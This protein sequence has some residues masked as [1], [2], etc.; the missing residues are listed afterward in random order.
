M[1]TM[2][3]LL[4]GNGP[5]KNIRDKARHADAVI[6]INHCQYRAHIPPEKMSHVFVVNS[7]DKMSVHRVV[8]MLRDLDVPKHTQIVFWGHLT[9]CSK[10]HGK[11]EH[12]E[13]ACR[14]KSRLPLKSVLKEYFENGNRPEI[15]E[16]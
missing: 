10:L 7:A 11:G 6:Q 15:G 2:R 8:H 3:Y 14:S 12:P 4:V 5:A 9:I 16:K 1:A 13:N